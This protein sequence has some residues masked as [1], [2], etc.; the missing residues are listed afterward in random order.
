MSR[1]ER[2]VADPSSYGRPPD[3]PEDWDRLIRQIDPAA[4]LLIVESRM[5]EA[6]R[7]RCAPEDILQE[8][9][10][11]AWRD[12]DRC[13]WR[14]RKSFR[15][16]LLTIIDHRLRD[17]VARE[18]ALKRGGG[19][20]PLSLS[21]VASSPSGASAAPI[22]STTPSRIALYREKAEAMRAALETLPDDV[23]DIVR[24]RLFEQLSLDDIGKGAGLDASTVLRRFR[25]G[26]ELYYKRLRDVMTSRRLPAGR[27]AGE[28][29]SAQEEGPDSASP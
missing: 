12:R 15:A 13:E 26:A 3:S 24:L 9:L 18:G 14:G 7:R 29:D 4:L 21:D 16:W 23:R 20:S 28:A 10:L 11:S 8:S 19:G 25:K 2:D 6:L 5:G 22:A 27:D 17:A 1:Y